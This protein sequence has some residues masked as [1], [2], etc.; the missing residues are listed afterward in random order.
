[1]IYRQ[2]NENFSPTYLEK[3]HDIVLQDV[4]HHI[5]AFLLY[6]HSGECDDMRQRVILSLSLDYYNKAKD[7][8]HDRIEAIKGLLQIP[9]DHIIR[10]RFSEAYPLW[11]IQK[12]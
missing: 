1:M 8:D 10:K 2:S 12:E 5:L 4:F 11:L 3:H 9:D 6:P 7:E